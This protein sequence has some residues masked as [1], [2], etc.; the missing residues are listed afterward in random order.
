LDLDFL[1]ALSPP[2]LSKML[3]IFSRS[4]FRRDQVRHDTN[5]LL[6]R[7]VLRL[8]KRDTIVDFLMASDAHERTALKRRQKQRTGKF[9]FYTIAAEDLLLMKLKA[10]RPQDWA[11]LLGVLRRQK[12]NVNWPYLRRWARRLGLSQEVAYLRS[13]T[14]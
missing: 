12:G 14:K 2:N 6:S 1:I 3:H 8:S 10:G 9:M 5:P 11:D 4:G 13:L 7:R